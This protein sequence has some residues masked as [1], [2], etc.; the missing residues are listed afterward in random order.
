MKELQP[1]LLHLQSNTLIDLPSKFYTLS[2]G[3]P[4]THSNPDINLA[5][6][7]D[8]DI[9]SRLHFEIRQ[10][11]GD[12]FIEDLSSIN[13][14]YL[15]NTLLEPLKPYKLNFNDRIDL[16]KGQRFT[17]LFVDLRGCLKSFE[18]SNFMLIASP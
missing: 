12:Y 14:T 3:K 2:I 1:T 5:D 18:G 15:N 11:R 9:V 6:F 4:G 10:V 8:S 17:L 7:P 16:G 13:G